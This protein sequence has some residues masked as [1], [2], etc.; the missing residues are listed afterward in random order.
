MAFGIVTALG[1]LGFTSSGV[2]T[3][4]YAAGMM[5]AAASST[6]GGVRARSFV[7]YLQSVGA[8]GLGVPATVTLATVAGAV[9]GIVAMSH[10]LLAGAFTAGLLSVVALVP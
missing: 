8:S 5:S 7:S 10:S 9:A 4:S 1:A 3:G 2:A 6:G